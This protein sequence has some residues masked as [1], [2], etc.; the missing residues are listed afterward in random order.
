MK[1]FI[2]GLVLGVAVSVSGSVL[3]ITAKPNT[4]MGDLNALEAKTAPIVVVEKKLSPQEQ[5]ARGYQYNIYTG[6]KLEASSMEQ[7]L[8]NIEAR[9][10]ALEKAQ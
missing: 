7:R 10:E 9:L 2:L 5:V 4:Q 6:E 1:K 3:A 8:R